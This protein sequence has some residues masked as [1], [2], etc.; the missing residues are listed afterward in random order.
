MR[1]SDLKLH[2]SHDR[3]FSPGPLLMEMST[4]TAQQAEGV[5]FFVRF[6]FSPHWAA[7][8]EVARGEAVPRAHPGCGQSGG[9][10]GF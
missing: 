1:N 5:F 9:N 10:S 3:D 8:G 6:L 2:C 4:G 7:L